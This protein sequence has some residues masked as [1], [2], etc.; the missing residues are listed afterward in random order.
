M[1]K[2]CR[3]FG[4]LFVAVLLTPAAGCGGG[5]AGTGGASSAEGGKNAEQTTV[6]SS[7][8]GSD[9]AAAGGARAKQPEDRADAKTRR[10]I[11]EIVDARVPEFDLSSDQIACLDENI[12]TM[13]SQ[14]MSAGATTPSGGETVTREK[15]T[16]E[17]F[18][19][20]LA[21]GCL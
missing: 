13:T 5:G 17:G 21:D 4:M 6:G 15:E 2:V 20:P 16:A 7:E 8:S 11:Q 3:L 12:A 9:N 1:H 18:L 19:G 10:Y 14:E